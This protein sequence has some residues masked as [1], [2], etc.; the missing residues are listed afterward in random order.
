MKP[1]KIRCR[2][3]KYLTARPLSR[4]RLFIFFSAFSH[5]GA[6]PKPCGPEAAI[7][8]VN[9]YVSFLIRPAIFLAGGRAEIQNL[10]L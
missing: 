8:A 3:K 4:Q 10:T 1:N 5:R 9:F 6:G 2:S 7:S